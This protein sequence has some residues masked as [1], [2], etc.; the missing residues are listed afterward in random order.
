MAYEE[1]LE[2]ITIPASADLSSYQYRAVKVGASGL[3][4]AGAGEV[5]IGILQ[6]NPDA[7]GQ[8]ASV[9][10]K[11]I[12]KLWVTAGTAISVNSA[13]RSSTIGYGVISSTG[14]TPY[15]FARALE[16]CSTGVTKIIP[17]LITHEGP[18]S[19]A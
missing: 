7:A 14:G 6:G 2:S 11:G 5:A 19:T 8:A 17:V 13:L 16:A 18:S 4:L 12:S 3:A 15:V 10:V 1:I 9:G